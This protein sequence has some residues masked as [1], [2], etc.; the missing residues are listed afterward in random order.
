VITYKI[1]AWAG[2]SACRGESGGVE[3]ALVRK[4]E[5]KRSLGRPRRRWKLNTKMDIQEVGCEGMD[6][7]DLTQDRDR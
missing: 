5:G 3:R 1:M 4:S 6:W 2:H 7:I